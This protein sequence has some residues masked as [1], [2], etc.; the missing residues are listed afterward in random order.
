MKKKFKDRPIIH[1]LHA[2]DFASRVARRRTW[3]QIAR[4]NERFKMRIERLKNV[5]E[6]VL[7]KKH[8]EVVNNKNHNK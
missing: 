8:N 4:D 5:I 1:V 3:E 2:W 7:V 6:P